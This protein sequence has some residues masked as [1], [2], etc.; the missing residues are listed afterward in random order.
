VVRERNLGLYVAQNL[1]EFCPVVDGF[2][3]TVKVN[4]PLGYDALFIVI[5]YVY[6]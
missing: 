4:L 1:N 6:T 3:F 5:Y 2:V